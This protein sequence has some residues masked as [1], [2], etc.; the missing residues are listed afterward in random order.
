RGVRAP[1]PRPRSRLRGRHRRARHRVPPR[2]GRSRRARL[3]HRHHRAEPEPG[4]CDVRA[5]RQR[6]DAARRDD[7][8]AALVTVLAVIV[9]CSI[10]AVVIL[11]SSMTVVSVT[12]G[13]KAM[14]E[15][16][17]AAEAGLAEAVLALRTGTCVDG[18][19]ASAPGTRPEYRYE[20]FTGGVS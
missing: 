2:R 19:V 18:E 12:T 11:I 13:G 17:A 7:R 5:L 3:R 9:I 14:V 1:R 4:G 20:I 10:L 8:G 6:L 15:A 16:R